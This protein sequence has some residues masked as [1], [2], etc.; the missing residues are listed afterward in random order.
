MSI[1]Y[2]RF[3]MKNGNLPNRDP[4]TGIR[5]GIIS[6]NELGEYAL[7]SFEP[8]YIL[9][10]PECGHEPGDDAPDKCPKCGYECDQ[11]GDSWCPDEAAEWVF[12]DNEYS[13]SLDECN[14]VWIFRSPYTTSRW[15]HCSPCAPGAAHLSDCDR[16]D[17]RHDLAYCLGPEWF[18]QD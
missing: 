5:Y 7:D 6:L 17:H 13:L 2:G 12:E 15:S 14:D 16:E 9:S 18:D 10:C 4:K 1:D 3:P 11:C 8:V